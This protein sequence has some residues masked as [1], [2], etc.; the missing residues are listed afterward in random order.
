MRDTSMDINKNW[1]QI[2]V[3]SQWRAIPETFVTFY[4]MELTFFYLISFQFCFVLF[5]MFVWVNMRFYFPL[6]TSTPH[7]WQQFSRK[8]WAN[9]KITWGITLWRI[10]SVTLYALLAYII[11]NKM[12]VRSY[13]LL[14]RHPLSSSS[15][16]TSQDMATTD[17][18]FQS[19]FK[20]PWLCPHNQISLTKEIQL[21]CHIWQRLLCLDLEPSFRPL[22][23][24]TKL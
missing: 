2:K 20:I 8:N 24:T 13:S 5:W 6:K 22:L 17:L 18:T 21:K 14:Q 16:L 23:K 19:L 9:L 1:K 4:K 12:T 7:A 3:V 11:S 15:I 10:N